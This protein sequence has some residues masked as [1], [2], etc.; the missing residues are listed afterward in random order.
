MYDKLNTLEPFYDNNFNFKNKTDSLH[1]YLKYIQ[2]DT[3]NWIKNLSQIDIPTN[4]IRILS[5]SP[6]IGYDNSIISQNDIFD[7]IQTIDVHMYKIP[8]IN[9][10]FVKNDAS[11]IVLNAISK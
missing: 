8:N 1:L 4:V 9:S 2:Q 10:E 6:H 5:L 3:T 11:R 7:I